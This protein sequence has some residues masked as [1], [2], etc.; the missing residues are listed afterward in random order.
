LKSPVA[1]GILSRK[2]VS[3]DLKDL[4]VKEN[5]ELIKIEKTKLPMIDL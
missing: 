4:Y 1:I 5:S 3:E 2:L